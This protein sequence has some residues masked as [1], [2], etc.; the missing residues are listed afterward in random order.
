MADGK[1][2]DVQRRFA[3]RWRQ[4]RDQG[5]GVA[6]GVDP[7]EELLVSWGLPPT[8]DGVDRFVDRVLEAAVGH[9]GIIKPQAAFFEAFGW[10]GMR[11][12]T[13]LC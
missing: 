8:I 4:L 10:E 5:R 7:S 11:T 9:V 6:F 3:V 1:R 2:G 12:L 13:R